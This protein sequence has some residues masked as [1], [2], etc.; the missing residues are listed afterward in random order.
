[1]S[2][3]KKMNESDGEFR[4][5]TKEAIRGL[6]SDIAELRDD[7]KSLNRRLNVLSLLLVVA[8]IERLPT[9]VSLIQAFELK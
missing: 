8:I 9:L 2:Y 4:G 6:T 1:M 5:T 7:V 3:N